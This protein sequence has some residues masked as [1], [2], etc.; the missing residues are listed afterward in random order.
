MLEQLENVKNRF[1]SLYRQQDTA[2]AELCKS[3][4]Q[5]DK[6]KRKSIRLTEL[7]ALLDID[8]GR[9]AAQVAKQQS[10]KAKRPSVLDGLMVPGKPG[11]SGPK[12]QKLKELWANVNEILVQPGDLS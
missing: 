10:A 1:D 3:F 8:S 4:P 5:Y 11:T 2:K 6:F 7:N 9:S 12:K